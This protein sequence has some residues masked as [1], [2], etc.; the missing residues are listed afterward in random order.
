MDDI[1]RALIAALR[2][3]ARASWAELGRLVGLSGPSGPG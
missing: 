1:D 3:N 2:S